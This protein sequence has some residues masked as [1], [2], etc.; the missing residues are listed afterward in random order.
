MT[1][2][3]V[4]WPFVLLNPVISVCRHGFKH[5]CPR[6]SMNDRKYLLMTIRGFLWSFVLLNPAISVFGQ[7][8][9]HECPRI[10]TNAPK[11]LLMTI[12]SV[13]ATLF[14][15]KNNSH[16]CNNYLIIKL[17][18]LWELSLISVTIRMALYFIVLIVFLFVKELLSWGDYFTRIFLPL[19]M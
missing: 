14:Y 10:F 9:K 6:I 11:Y 13:K 8:F 1:I 16:N 15:N 7:G 5:E 4:L 18:K 19:W 12:R 17:F 3:G 2:R